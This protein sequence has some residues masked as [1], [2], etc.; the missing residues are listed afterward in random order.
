M[1]RTYQRT[2]T[3]MM[4]GGNRKPANPDAGWDQGGGQDRGLTDQVFLG[5]ANSQR[6]GAHQSRRI[7][8]HARSVTLHLPEHWPWQQP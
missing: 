5:L 6:N 7:A 1:Y 3:M 8:R 4:S 2:A